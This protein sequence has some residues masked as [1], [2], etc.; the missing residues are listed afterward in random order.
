MGEELVYLRDVQWKGQTQREK[1]RKE[2]VEGGRVGL[3][4]KCLVAETEEEGEKE[5][6]SRSN[7]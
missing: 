6:E 3:P 4:L 5:E 1:K 2:E 7:T